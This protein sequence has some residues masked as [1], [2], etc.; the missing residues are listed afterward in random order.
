MVVVVV[1]VEGHVRNKST[2]KRRNGVW[3]SNH[4]QEYLEDRERERAIR[5]TE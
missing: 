3:V 5:D 4:H 1:V 2:T